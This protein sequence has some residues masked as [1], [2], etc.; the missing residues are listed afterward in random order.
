MAA[1]TVTLEAAMAT[2]LVCFGEHPAA[3]EQQHPE[4]FAR[5]VNAWGKSDIGVPEWVQQASARLGGSKHADS[6]R[7]E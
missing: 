4:E 7:Y 3:F 1:A 5:L 6:G 2:L